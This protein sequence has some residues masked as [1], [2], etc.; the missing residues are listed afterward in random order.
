M[1]L[2]QRRTTLTPRSTVGEL[3]L[4]GQFLCYTLEDTVREIVGVPVKVW[5]IPG[6]TAI[7][8]GM[9]AVTITPSPRFGKDLPLLLDVPGFSGVRIHT[10]NTPEDTEGCILVGNKVGADQVIESRGAFTALY[11]LIEAAL[12]GGEPVNLDIRNP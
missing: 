9:Y 8:A 5:K 10:G 12:A 2:V 4:D 6:Q 7:P 11:D 3:Y 1:N